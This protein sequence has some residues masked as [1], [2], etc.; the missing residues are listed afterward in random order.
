MRLRRATWAALTLWGLACA[1][2]AWGA[3]VSTP[4][5]PP[6]VTPIAA[7]LGLAPDEVRDALVGA[8]THGPVTFGLEAAGPSGLVQTVRLSELLQDGAAA[9][10]EARGRNHALSHLPAAWSQCSAKF[11]DDAAAPQVDDAYLDVLVFRDGKFLR[12]QP[13]PSDRPLRALPGADSLDGGVAVLDRWS[14]AVNPSR[15][16][17]TVCRREERRAPPPPPRVQRSANPQDLAGLPFLPFMPFLNARRLAAKAKGT[18]LYDAL[19]PGRRLADAPAIRLSHN[20][21]AREISTKAAGY[22]V[23][24]ID[25]GAYPSLNTSDVDDYG[26]VGVRGGVVA[27]RAREA[28]ESGVIVG[29]RP[30][31]PVRFIPPAPSTARASGCDSRRR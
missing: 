20:A 24:R 30:A 13:A 16:L 17:R 25:M 8:K 21:L 3:I 1:S 2:C 10:S 6:R 14:A 15:M 12:L 9:E 26:L 22:Q 18:V 29:D 7:L 23:F 5:G 31:P 19:A 27:W 4:L 28:A 11:A